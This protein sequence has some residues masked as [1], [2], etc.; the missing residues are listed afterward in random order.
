MQAALS[1]QRFGYFVY[2]GK[3]YDVIGQLTR[4]LRS[5]PD[6]LGNLTVRTMDGSQM[7]RLDNLISLSES[8]SPP[9]L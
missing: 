6:D 2:N 3:Q 9:E 4:D 5:R 7:V 8:S 1:G